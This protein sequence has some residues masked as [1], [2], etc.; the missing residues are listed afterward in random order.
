MIKVL[1]YDYCSGDADCKL[2]LDTDK[3]T[4]EDAQILLD[5]FDWDYDEDA[6]PVYEYMKK[7]AMQC[8]EIATSERCNAKGVISEIK[9]MEGWP[10]LD[11]T[12]G[13]TLLDVSRYEF[14]DD[15]LELK[16]E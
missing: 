16:E 6:D 15:F 13:I 2:Q 3:F 12:N 5:F 4:K 11:G 7:V 10:Y 14:L 8:I 1:N 9:Q